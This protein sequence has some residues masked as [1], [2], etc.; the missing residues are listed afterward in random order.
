MANNNNIDKKSSNGDLEY[1]GVTIN[2]K[3]V[4]NAQ[5]KAYLNDATLANSARRQKKSLKSNPKKRLNGTEEKDNSSNLLSK[6]NQLQSLGN[7]EK[8]Q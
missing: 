3:V 1:P 5:N 8:Q 7:L 6:K 4:E 2:T